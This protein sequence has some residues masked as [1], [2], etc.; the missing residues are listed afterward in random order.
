[1]GRSDSSGGGAVSRAAIYIP[2]ILKHEGGFVNHP[3]DPGGATNWG[4]TIGTLKRLKID[5]DGDGDS[6]IVD[7]RNLR[8][9][10]AVRVFK[11]FYADAVKADFL[12]PGLDYAM[13]D[14][15]VNSGPGRAAQHLQ[16]ILG[17]EADGDIGP[18]TLAAVAQA[19]AA[20]LIVALSE[21]RLRFMRSLPIWDTFKNGWT[22]RVAD[23]QRQ[24]LLDARTKTQPGAI[25]TGGAKP[26][27]PPPVKP[28]NPHDHGKP[29]APPPPAPDN[30]HE[31][32]WWVALI[33]WLFG[34]RGS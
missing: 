1:M 16:R 30:S 18:K 33:E 4:V 28:D 7:L 32:A 25:S 15:A 22:A 34:K 29:A 12:P 9:S 14:F 2:L 21:S 5:V 11:L 19:D 31:R 26:I 8:E 3:K 6:D 24:A 17:V 10:D 23:V 20:A 13:T 27:T